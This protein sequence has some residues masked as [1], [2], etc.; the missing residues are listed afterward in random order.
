MGG[1]LEPQGFGFVSLFWLLQPRG[2]GLRCAARGATACMAAMH[3]LTSADATAVNGSAVS[4]SRGHAL[5]GVDQLSMHAS[6]RIADLGAATW[7]ASPG[8]AHGCCACALSQDLPDEVARPCS[9]PCALAPP[10]LIP[11]AR[12]GITGRKRACRYPPME[13]A[14]CGRQ[15]RH[16]LRN[17]LQCMQ[18]EDRGALHAVA[19]DKHIASDK[20]VASNTL[21][22]ICRTASCTVLQVGSKCWMQAPL[23]A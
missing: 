13:D 6:T 15:R 18:G 21:T 16:H 17:A 11:S 10:E 5:R 23:T 20:H 19:S 4:H 22:E 12:P 9:M 7:V 1:V 2:H 8:R 3:A 14:S